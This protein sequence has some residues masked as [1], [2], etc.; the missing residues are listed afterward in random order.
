MIASDAYVIGVDYGS[1]SVR[2]IIADAS[3]GNEIASAVFYYPRWKDQ[4]YCNAND[5]R[6]R[7]HPLDYIE[8]L[9]HTIKA[10]IAKA[11]PAVAA[12]IKA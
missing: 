2:T 9:E 5:N 7:Q 6:F 1:D 11:G 12:N 3:N 10:C 4:L 8:G